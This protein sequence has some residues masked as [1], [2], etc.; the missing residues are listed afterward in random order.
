MSEVGI[1]E[2]RRTLKDWVDRARSG[3]EVIITDR[4]EP[5]ARLSGVGS[6]SLWEELLAEGRIS[7]PASTVRPIARA[8][9]RI[10][11]EGSVSELIVTER[12]RHR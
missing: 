11:A 4:G 2:L 6:T 12:D 7:R 1:A 8:A 3:D 9:H 5:V 10:Q